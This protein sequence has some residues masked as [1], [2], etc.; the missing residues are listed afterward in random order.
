M[1]TFKRISAILDLSVSVCV[2]VCVCVCLQATNIQQHNTKVI[3]TKKY[4]TQAR[5][6]TAHLLNYYWTTKRGN[7]KIHPNKQQ[8]TKDILLMMSHRQK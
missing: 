7:L 8:I 6:V 1:Y 3:S 4:H 2:C 5:L